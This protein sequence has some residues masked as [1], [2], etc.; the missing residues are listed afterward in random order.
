LDVGKYIDFDKKQEKKNTMWHFFDRGDGVAEI[1]Q[2]ILEWAIQGDSDSIWLKFPE[3]VTKKATF[4][5]LV[6]GADILCDNVNSEY[7]D[8]LKMVFNSPDYRLKEAQSTREVVCDSIFILTKKRYI[9]RVVDEE[10]KRHDPFKLKTMGVELKKANTSKITKKFLQELVDMILDGYEREDIITRMKEVE[11]EFKKADIRDLVTTMNAK[12]IKKAEKTY[13]LTGGFANVHYASKAAI[14]YNIRCTNMDR[15]VVAGDKISLVYVRTNEGVIGYPADMN[16]LPEWLLNIQL[17]YDKLWRNC[18]KT[19]TNYLKALG[20]DIASQKE[21]I[22]KELFGL[23]KV[24]K[25]SKK[26][27]KK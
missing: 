14:A 18:K 5:E 16:T 26:R 20:W 11:K 15:K 27:G 9:A 21:A 19:M 8:F 17:D 13:E 6:E 4:D 2:E 10:G 24:D 7:P 23:V 3:S 22:G 25:K 12:T 1:K